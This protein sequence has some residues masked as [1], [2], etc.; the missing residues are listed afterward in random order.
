MSTTAPVPS[1]L[2]DQIARLLP[3][4][5]AH[6]RWFARPPEPIEPGPRAVLVVESATLESGWPG[7]V[8]LVIEAGGARYQVLVGMRPLVQGEEAM[9]GQDWAV[10]GSVEIDGTPVM[11]YDATADHELALGMARL[12][13]VNDPFT[14]VRLV[15]AEQSNTSLVFDDAVIL[16][17][18]RRVET[19]PNPDV[20]VTMGLD[21]VGFNHVAAPRGAWNRLGYDLAIAQEFLAGGSEGWALALTSLRDMYQSGLQPENAG[22]DFGAEARRLGNMTARMHLGLAK[23]FGTEEV[24]RHRW[25]DEVSSGISALERLSPESHLD[26]HGFDSILDE[27]RMGI[28]SCSVTCRV[29]G[30]YH[31]GQ[32]MRTEVGWFVLDFEG[33]PLRSL[34][35]R[36]AR[37]SP[38]RDVAGMLRSFHYAAISA[39]DGRQKLGN[40]ALSWELRNRECFLR[41]YLSTPGIDELVSGEPDAVLVVLRAFEL[42]KAAYE[43]AYEKAYRPDWSHIPLDALERLAAPSRAL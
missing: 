1:V 7:L 17:L 13:G 15:G 10:L 35:D 39:L 3:D 34:H 28:E 37:R 8:W 38:L 23:A 9:A 40:L 32:T 18:Y 36:R 16:K 11:A 29:H 22:G 4:F 27:A 19:G 12:A 24:D 41:G 6:Q 42:G 30:D 5:L 20:E 31:L 43:L 33:E 25:L 14:R 21:A 26:R 2:L